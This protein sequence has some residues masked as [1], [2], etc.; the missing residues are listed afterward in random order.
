MAWQVFLGVLLGIYLLSGLRIIY[1][2]ERGIKF[3][4]GKYSGIMKPGLNFIFLFFQTMRKVD[5]RVRVIDV[6]TQE[7]ITKDNITVGL[8]AVIYYQVRDPEKAILAVEHYN[9]AISQ[10][11]Q[12]TMRNVAGE[13]ELDDLLS[14]RNVIAEKI[15]Q[16]VDKV[17]DPWGILVSGVELK[18]ITLPQE[19]K[20]VIGRQAEA[21]REKRA[22]IIKSEGE[23]IASQNIAKAASILAKA[24]GGL[25]IRTLHT[26][27]DVSSDQSNTIIFTI[28]LEVL[29]AFSG[30][31]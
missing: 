27:N 24:D 29:R 22:V 18:D 16:I 8:N 21:E 2:Y 10:L 3:T 9:Y 5:M 15:R 1:E 7:G 20:R 31:K 19:L 13:V 14:K 30:K 25:H 4:L 6:P 28:P 26:L 17:S 11:A 12:T 23:V